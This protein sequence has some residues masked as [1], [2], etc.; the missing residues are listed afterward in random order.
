[1]PMSFADGISTPTSNCKQETS[2]S[3]R[4]FAITVFAAAASTSASAANWE[5]APRVEGGYRYSD[6]Y[7][8]D[9]PGAEI[10]VS[11]LEADAQVDF[12]TVDPRTNFSV[13]P[14]IRSTYFPDES[15]EDSTDY[16]L[17]GEFSDVTPR[18]RLRVAADWSEED[19]VRSE[20]ETADVTS[21]LGEPDAVGAG[22]IIE[23]NR[24]DLYRLLPSYAYDFTQRYRMELDA[25]YTEA[26]YEQVS[27]GGQQDFRQYGASGGFGILTS[28]RSSLMFRLTASHYDTA[29]DADAVG[30]EVEWG[31]DFTENSRMYVRLGAQQTEPEDGD[32]STDFVGGVGGQWTSPRN[33]LFLD[34]TRSINA[35]SAG[36]VVERHQLRLRLEHDVSPTVAV[37]LGV[38][39][40]RDAAVEEVSS[41]PTRQ[42]ATA[43][44]G[45][46]WRWNRALAL[47][48]T[49][50]YKWQEYDDE[51]SDASSNAF[52]ISVVYEPKRAE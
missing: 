33:Q 31:R 46:E 24:R 1:M 37:L 50:D 17:G 25:N 22:R 40:V 27:V 2:L 20:L 49:Y 16:F 35:S 8:L 7:R 42:Y 12:R 26:D 47:R 11:G 5:V 43:Q 13:T 52:L 34:L 14:R 21:D 48:A 41:Y 38:R 32:A 15:D 9:L 44:T 30:G 19:V 36:T 45:I 39:A 28:Q 6:N 29:V 4:K 10:D 18:S 23:R 51:P 3:Y